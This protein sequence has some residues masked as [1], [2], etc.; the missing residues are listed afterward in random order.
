MADPMRG[1]QPSRPPASSSKALPQQPSGE[2]PSPVEQGFNPP[3]ASSDQRIESHEPALRSP[4]AK[5]PQRVRAT[6]DFEGGQGPDELP[7]RRGDIIRVLECVYADWWKGELKGKTGI[8]PANRVV[9]GYPVHC[10][11]Q[12]R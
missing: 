8:F 5:T 7:F 6:Y 10:S 4:T 2:P 1:F 11:L 12:P 3:S 9:S